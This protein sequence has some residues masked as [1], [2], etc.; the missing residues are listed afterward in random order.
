[1]RIRRASK[2]ESIGQSPLAQPLDLDTFSYSLGIA[3]NTLATIQQI[4]ADYRERIDPPENKGSIDDH[5]KY[6]RNRNF[7]KLI[8]YTFNDGIA[9]HQTTRGTFVDFANRLRLPDQG[10]PDYYRAA[11]NVDAQCI[12]PEP[13]NLGGVEEIAQNELALTVVSSMQQA[14]IQGAITNWSGYH[15]VRPQSVSH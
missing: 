4:L 9:L 14:V 11:F 15:E 5:N 8:I 12:I 2:P 3:T 10:D 1:M 7:G 13:V 6:L